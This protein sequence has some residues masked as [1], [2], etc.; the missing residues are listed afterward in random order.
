MLS[1]RMVK[2]CRNSICKPLSIIFNDCL[3][4]GKLPSDQRKTHFV[5]IHKKGDKQ[6]LK[7]CGPISLLSVCS[8]SFECLI[9]DELF[10]CLTDNKLV[11]PNQF[12]FKPGDS[13]INQLLAIT[14]KIRK[15]FDDGFEER[16]V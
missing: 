4:E 11:S 7:S 8:K 9:Y 15:L 10:T 3:K 5:N 12:R 6:C 13:G 16:G 1:V 14:Q 2:L